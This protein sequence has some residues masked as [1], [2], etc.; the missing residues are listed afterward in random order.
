[1]AG[2]PGSSL[3]THDLQWVGLLSVNWRLYVRVWWDNE[4][5]CVC[6]MAHGACSDT[7]SVPAWPTS[8]SFVSQ[9]CS[10]TQPQSCQY[11][12]HAETGLNNLKKSLRNLGSKKQSW[13]IIITTQPRKALAPCPP[14]PKRVG[15]LQLLHLR[16]G[17]TTMA[18]PNSAP[19]SASVRLPT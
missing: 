17:P 11:G 16:R 6:Q 19:S 1:M 8:S 14:G 2:E 12:F 18:I 13:H 4:C 9:W 15:G 10:D 3:F 7:G 5:M